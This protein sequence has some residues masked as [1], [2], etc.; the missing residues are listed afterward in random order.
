MEAGLTISSARAVASNL[1]LSSK[2]LDNLIAF[3]APDLRW[4]SADE[5]LFQEGDL[6]STLFEIAQGSVMVMRLLPDGRRQILDIA[7]PGRFIGLTAGETHDC[8]AIA[9]QHTAVHNHDREQILTAPRHGASIAAA[10]FDEIH[11][12]RDLAVAL[13]RKTALERLAGFLLAMTGNDHRSRIELFLPVSRLEIADHL[14]LAIETVCRNF[15]R[16]KRD[17][18]ILL[19]GNHRLTILD[20]E[21][22]KKIAAG[23]PTQDASKTARV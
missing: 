8:T 6:A 2:C 1:S 10:M 14:G 7:R 20:K 15:T 23:H 3:P 4:F 19:E 22:L 16:M 5:A 13:G 12:L 11:R 21:A 18:L 17:G 9:L